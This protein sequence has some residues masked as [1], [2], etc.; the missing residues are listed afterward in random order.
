MTRRIQNFCKKAV[1][2]LVVRRRRQREI[3][4]S[5]KIEVILAQST[6]PD[7]RRSE[8]DFDCLQSR[9]NG[10]PEY[11]F[12]P[13]SLWKRGAERAATLVD[14]VS[15]T[16]HPA[17]VLEVGC[18]DGMTGV[19]L[20]SFGHRVTLSDMEDWRD[21]R[22]RT[23]T[24]IEEVLE[25]GLPLPDAA[26]DLVYSFNSFEH[27][28][29]PAK[30]FRELTRLCR[31]GGIMHLDFGPLYP[32]AWGLHAYSSLK[33]PYPQYLFSQAFLEQKLGELGIW[34]LGR[35]LDQLQPLNEWRVDDFLKLW[36]TDSWTTIHLCTGGPHEYLTL[37]EEY[38][39]AF[40]GRGLSVEDL[41]TQ[42]IRVTL[43]RNDVSAALREI[44]TRRNA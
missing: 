39:E 41:T 16:D 24:F 6:P 22:A 36:K 27:F 4:R 37:V 8:A 26:F 38:P 20:T 34:D 17:R 44:E 32:S 18:G 10:V 2:T 28:Q 25:A 15:F 19:L 7:T 13:R 23:L 5:R 42:W 3:R 21:P 29:D 31:P 14:L 1:R 30:C 40:R 33:M 35:R 11:G 12:D 43:R 9:Y